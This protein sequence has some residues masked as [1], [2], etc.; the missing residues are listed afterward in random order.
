[1]S[2]LLAEFQD[3]RPRSV[4]GELDCMENVAWT[5]WKSGELERAIQMVS[6]ALQLIEL[7]QASE[8][9]QWKWQTARLMDIRS[10]ARW[11]AGDTDGAVHDMQCA[12]RW[13]SHYGL[14]S[15][16]DNLNTLAEWQA[17]MED[18]PSSQT[19]NKRHKQM[20]DGLVNLMFDDGL[21][22][23]VR[24]EGKSRLCGNH[25]SGLRH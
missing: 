1:M 15:I 8:N 7:L 5:T 22:A 18:K 25:T 11:D 24:E 20:L 14:A 21:P 4:L 12:I 6:D 23:P 3:H 9:E 17:E 2:S 19:N 13:K 10:I 16:V